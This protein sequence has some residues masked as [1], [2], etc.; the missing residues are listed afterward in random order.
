[1]L[2][3]NKFKKVNDSLIKT[4]ESKFQ[5]SV[6]KIKNKLTKRKIFKNIVSGSC[7]GKMYGNAKGLPSQPV[8]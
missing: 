3:N 7:P 1:M 8:N 4:I 5:R 2:N 6:C